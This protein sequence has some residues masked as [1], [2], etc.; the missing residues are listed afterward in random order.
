M[1]KIRQE[2]V[3]QIGT[4]R[5]KKYHQE[6]CQ[7]FREHAPEQ[8]ESMN[9]V[10]LE[11]HIA[12]SVEKAR[13]YGATSGVAIVQFVS[14]TLVSGLDFDKDPEIHAYLTAPE[15]DPDDKI[16]KLANSLAEALR[17]HG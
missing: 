12:T 7:Y 3:D 6:L 15:Y 5:E 13:G 16:E 2:Q 17:L 1:F 9:E 8:V 11:A 10:Q 4:S 14:M